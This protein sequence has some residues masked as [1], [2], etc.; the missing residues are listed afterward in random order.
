MTSIKRALTLLIAPIIALSCF[1]C[2][3]DRAPTESQSS[4]AAKVAAVSQLDRQ[5]ARAVLGNAIMV[6]NPEYLVEAEDP[7]FIEPSGAEGFRLPFTVK[8]LGFESLTKK[9]PWLRRYEVVA[10]KAGDLVMEPPRLPATTM[11]G[12]IAGVNDPKT[13]NIDHLLARM[14]K[15]LRV[16][17]VVELRNPLTKSELQKSPSGFI[18]DVFFSPFSA[19]LRPIFWRIGPGCAGMFLPP[20]Q[21][22]TDIIAQFTN[23]VSILRDSD[24]ATLASLGLNLSEIRAAA[25]SP[26]IYGYVIDGPPE[27]VRAYATGPN[28]K[29]AEIIQVVDN[30]MD[31]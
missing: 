11:T 18:T 27:T 7:S 30:N 2:S 15:L 5:R 20:C 12:F 1:G 29:A 9:E 19:E 22:D 31:S 23:W 13:S 24:H 25:A 8:P 4:P 28:I 3:E 26:R 10:T 16:F 21:S 6:A 17:A 14:P